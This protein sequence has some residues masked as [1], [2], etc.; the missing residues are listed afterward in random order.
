MAQTRYSRQQRSICHM[1]ATAAVLL[2]ETSHRPAATISPLC[3][4]Q[5]PAAATALLLE[6]CTAHSSLPCVTPSGPPPGLHPCSTA[7]V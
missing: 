7:G 3:Y 4:L 2:E 6:H 5:W 1:Q